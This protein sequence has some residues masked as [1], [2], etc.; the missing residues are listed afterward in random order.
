MKKLELNQMEN[1][2]GGAGCLRKSV[3]WG[4]VGVTM[5]IIHPVLGFAF[6]VACSELVEVD[7]C[8][9]L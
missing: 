7:D 8:N 2:Q 6:S 4:I 9:L 5:G 1:L 3:G